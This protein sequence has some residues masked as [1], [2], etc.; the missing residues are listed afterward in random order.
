V[1]ADLG[2]APAASRVLE[3]D[4]GEAARRR[5]TLPVLRGVRPD[6]Y[7]VPADTIKID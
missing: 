1:L 7:G 5:E 6:A 3:L 4:L 2:T